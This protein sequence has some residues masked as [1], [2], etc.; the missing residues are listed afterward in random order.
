VGLVERDYVMRM[1]QQLAELLARLLKLK[2]A[3]RY[4]EAT[5]VLESGCA[6]LLGIDFKTLALVD[7]PSA[8]SLLSEPMRIRTFARLLEELADL[9]HE[10]G[11]EARS[12]ARAGHALEMYLEVLAR[13]ADDAEA[14]AGV[15]RLKHRVAI[16]RLPERYQRMLKVP[17][18]PPG[19]GATPA[20]TV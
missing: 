15:E 14:R 5:E 10:S 16:D 20:D 11:S 17:T 7:S 1:V 6:S 2:S 3:K 8:A 9:S 13:K 18:A 19:S 12:L 4:D